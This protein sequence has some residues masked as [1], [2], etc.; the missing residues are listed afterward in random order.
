MVRRQVIAIVIALAAICPILGAA[1]S[2]TVFSLVAPQAKA[3]FVAGE[4]NHWS[5]TATP[6]KRDADG[7]WTATVPLPVGKHAYKFI[8]DGEWKVDDANPEQ[9]QDGFGGMNSVMT[10]SDPGVDPVVNEKDA[11]RREAMHAFTKSDF[12]RLE[13]TADD[14]RRNKTR[15]SDGLWKLK[16]FYDGLNAKNEIGEKKDWRPWFE[17]MERWKEQFPESITQPVVLAR[18]RLDYADAVHDESSD[19]SVGNARAVLEAATNSS[20]SRCPNWYYVMQSIARRQ[21]WKRDEY[22]KLLAVA[23]AAEPSYY[24]YYSSA[25]EFFLSH[26]QHGKGE[27]ERV[28][29]QAATKFDPAEGMAAYS[30]TVWFMES[31]FDNIFDQTTVTWTKLRQGFLDMQKRYPDSRWNANA[32][33]RFAVHAKD[34]Q[35]ASEL[36]RRIGDHGDPNWGGYA[37]YDMARMWA[38]PSTPSWRIEPL[39]TITQPAKPA[40]Q[41]ITFS[42]DGKVLAGGTQNGRV[43]LWDSTS[44]Q[45]IWSERVAPFPVMSVAFSPDGKLLAAGAGQT[46]RATEPGVAKVWDMA[47]K[48]E[49]ASASPKGVV[50]E[51]AFTPDSKTLALSGGLW[52]SQ[53]ESTLLDLATKESRALPW[54]ANH[55]HILKG[56]AISP[57][58]KTLVTDCYQ[59][60]T[61]WSLAE[62]RVLFDTRNLVKCFVLS[63][64]F[65]P[66]GK[67]L[68]TCGAPMRGHNDNEPGELTLWDT[69]TWKP[70]TPRAQLDAGGLVGIAYSPDGKWIAGGGYDQ[71]LHVWDAATLQSKAIYIGHD[72][73]IW[74]VAFSPDG[75]AVASASDDGAIKFWKLP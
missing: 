31:W 75:N 55:D 16:E 6:L 54:T 46:Y 7:R 14:F 21:D 29:E 10:V 17:K 72:G 5:K 23:A 9:A 58:G 53:A 25:A 22:E 74:S 35:T 61:V 40:I 20:S 68:I 18:G 59:S 13:K 56:V 12:A 47:T 34:R 66:D 26:G 42:S 65:S 28:A 67:K 51:V 32:F 8:V 43:V 48:E 4:F 70:R 37:R 41:S 1:E 19:E 49:V 11:V 57:D 45:E 2:N 24:Y 52:E 50:W 33:C 63:L 60:I 15:F 36:F 3:V 64:A 27:L 73:M 69:A 30:R 39:L 71:A 62:N 38:D 44:G